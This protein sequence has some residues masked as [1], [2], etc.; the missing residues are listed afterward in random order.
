MNGT[1]WIVFFISLVCALGVPVLVAIGSGC[2]EQGFADRGA[3]FMAS[4]TLCAVMFFGCLWLARV[5]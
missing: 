3:F 5:D 2:M 1:K 4:A